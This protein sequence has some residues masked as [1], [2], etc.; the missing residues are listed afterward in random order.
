MF[1][2]HP[3][4]GSLNAT[5]SIP[6]GGLR[7]AI[8]SKPL[9]DSLTVL[10]ILLIGVLTAA[11]VG[12]YLVDWDRHRAL[13]ERKLSEAAGTPVTVAGP[14]DLKLLPKPLFRFGDV[15]VGDGVGGR[16]RLGAG[17]LDAELSLAA[18][19]RGQVQV[20]DTTLVRPKLDLVQG[21]DGGFG[22]GLPTGA[23]ADRVAFDHLGLRDGT[24]DLTLADGRRATLKGI[25]LDGEAASLRGP[26]KAS[27]R[28]GGLPFRLGTGA[29]DGGRLRVKLSVEGAGARPSLDLDGTAAARPGGR[30]PGFDGSATATGQVALDGTPAAVP[31]RGTAKLSADRDGAVATEVE[32]RAGADLR[33]LI[34]SG[35]GTAGYAA[36]AAPPRA[37]L[38]LHGAVLDI[39]DLAVPPAASD[40]APPKGLDLVRLLLRGVGD[41]AGL[42]G[43]PLRL[44]LDASFDTA[45]LAG[46]TVLG[47][48]ARLRLG[49]EPGAALTFG[50]DGPDGARLALDG[51][52]E[53]RPPPPV[54]GPFG[55]A[56]APSSA[57]FRG[58]GEVRAVDVRRIAAWLRP[59]APDVA[60]WIAATVP[61]RSVSARGTVDASSAGISARDLDLRVDGSA[62]GGTL[63]F[64]RAGGSER[65]RLFADLS[66]DALALDGL[67][68]LS[69]AA[70]ASRD[71]DVDLSLAARAVTLA[72]S[73]AGAVA[74]G[75]VALRV[76]TSR[77]AA[78]L[79]NLTL[80]LD[81]G[82]LDATASRDPRGARGELHV[83]APQFGPLADAV[84]PLLP[85][86]AASALRARGAVL[87]PVDATMRV[88][89]A[90][91]PDGA[92]A[93]TAFALAGTAGGTRIDAALRPDGPAAGRDAAHRSVAVSLRAEATE[94]T[95]LL[96]L[97]GF[98]APGP[99][100]GPARLSGTGEGTLAD[101]FAGALDASLGDTALS[102]A[103]RAGAAGGAGRLA[104]R[105]PDLRPALAGLGVPQ[106]GAAV[107]AD[108]AGD[109]AFDGAA[110]SWRGLAGHV[111]GTGV[112]GD[113]A[114]D[115]A[116]RRGPGGEPLPVLHGR[117]AVDRL[118]AEALLGLALGPA[119]SPPPGAPWSA[120]AFAPPPRALPRGELALTV[121]DM[122]LRGGLAG[123]AVSLTL[124]T[125]PD[126]VVLADVR[127]GV[128][129]GAFDGGL[130]IRR[131]GPA[132]TLSGRADW[133]GVALDLGGI[134][135]SVGGSE[136]VAASGTNPAA[137][138]ASLAGTGTVRL[139]GATLART[140][141]GAP[142]RV[143]AAVGARD[144]A[145]ERGSSAAEP[146]PPD[147]DALRRDV[148]AALDAGP[149]LIGTAEA[150][151]VLT[152]GVLRI[153]PL[154]Q[155][156]TAVLPGQGGPASAGWTAETGLALDLGRMAL[157]SRVHLRVAPAGWEVAATRTGPLGGDAPRTVDVAGLVEAVQAQS[158]ARA[159]D[160]I[161]VMEQDIRERAA[162]NRQL[163]GIVQRRQF[164][165]DEAAAAEAQ[166][167]AVARAEAQ[168]AAEAQ[169]A[170][171]EQRRAD[172]ARQK[173]EDARVRTE[174]ESAARAGAARDQAARDE[175]EKQRFIDRAL[176]A[177]DPPLDLG[178][179]DDPLDR[180][181]S[182][183]GQ[184]PRAKG[185]D[186]FDLPS[187]P[188]IVKE[189][190]A[191][192]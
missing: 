9:R 134:A 55:A 106:P 131:D 16:P 114:L 123:R 109:L 95:D 70:A 10:A 74:A 136:D 122:P 82:R 178:T 59:A 150:P 91:E 97:L 130:S 174:V 5:P 126:G 100:K 156:G 120:Q 35:D 42:V 78:R 113:L 155:T 11:L 4:R 33:A 164:E 48:A 46:R 79:E 98:G 76:T 133:R 121:G 39:D 163:K 28:I 166:K 27:G 167:A 7:T 160:R 1:P 147:A 96:R 173:A 189:R 93:P 102:Y 190:G 24:L 26:F 99:V 62:F 104:L 143:L 145:A 61:G 124:R 77:D 135:G 177:T 181:R 157:T 18:L 154:R 49:P 43:L 13:I 45:T 81:G 132:A 119:A 69:A 183:A 20:V 110:A 19:M 118:P 25:D 149:L 168:A 138:V 179:Q 105:S 92:L 115:L 171:A 80:D 94:G 41:G 152:G 89:A 101:G 58:R 68:D 88:E 125:A 137:L 22:L 188:S 64:T 67:P 170:A 30:G 187:P 86:A 87:S 63:S 141:P 85:A 107:P 159:Q 153:G 90:A 29:I 191:A 185:R 72:S 148:G 111:A 172:A 169:K 180:L 66:S 175:A 14:I 31:W 146:T 128:G 103:G 117:I 12:P 15:T 162:F 37:A 142:A 60:D 2:H 127:G 83:S 184:S 36:G 182:P 38:R 108:A 186:P 84:T 165:R 17:S 44:D 158:I 56:P 52:V 50:V 112:A 139:S 192:P 176:K 71:L 3:I 129:G 51:R 57:V 21:K 47:T 34:A 151:A 53:P 75:H 65:A 116:P 161:D 73:S 144:A 6:A 140:D 23:S 54:A 40:I 8:A 32:L